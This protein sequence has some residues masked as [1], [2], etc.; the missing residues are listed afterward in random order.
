MSVKVSFIVPAYNVQKYIKK[1]VDSI[2]NQS[3][4]DIE[5]IVVNQYDDKRLKIISQKNVGLTTTKNN[6]I[7][8]C[9]GEYIITVD[10]DDFIE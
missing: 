2:L 4:K 7:K 6:G 10:A 1:C 9:S 8:I 3:L 5:I